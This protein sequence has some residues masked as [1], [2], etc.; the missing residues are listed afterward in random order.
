MAANMAHVMRIAEQMSDV[1][2]DMFGPAVSVRSAFHR[3]RHRPHC[4]RPH[5]AA[6]CPFPYLMQPVDGAFRPL[7]AEASD[8]GSQIPRVFSL[9]RRVSRRPMLRI[10]LGLIPAGGD[11]M[12]PRAQADR[13]PCAKPAH[14]M[15]GKV[16]ERGGNMLDVAHCLRKQGDAVPAACRQR[17]QRSLAGACG[18]DIQQFC[19]NVQ[20]GQNRLH[21]C[22]AP[23]AK[24]L[25]A[26]CAAYFGVRCRLGPA[27]PPRRPDDALIAVEQKHIASDGTKGAPDAEGDA[28]QSLDRDLV[29]KL[30]HGA[31]AHRQSVESAH[32]A[33]HQRQHTRQASHEDK[34]GRRSDEDGGDERVAYAESASANQGAV[35]RGQAALRSIPRWALLSGVAAGTVVLALVMLG[36]V[37]YHR[38]RQAAIQA[39]HYRLMMT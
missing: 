32:E 11:R 17:L 1:P 10:R 20:P 7:A 6:S 36:A 31:R 25:S 5:A 34:P 18:D 14:D 39:E 19:P 9:L 27:P 13:C 23:H 30:R 33:H 2:D 22:L 21:T 28:T 37:V 4:V 35:A 8:S 26:S 12:R 29:R 24:E 38:R 3:S 15:C 16:I